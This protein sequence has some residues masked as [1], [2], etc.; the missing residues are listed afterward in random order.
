MSEPVATVKAY[1]RT[2]GAVVTVERPGRPKHRYV[3]TLRRYHWLREWT[4]T[5]GAGFARPNCWR[6]SGAW[7]RSSLTVYL[8]SQST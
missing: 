3:V 6:T 7:M 4:L 5:R 2:G 1:R 8:W